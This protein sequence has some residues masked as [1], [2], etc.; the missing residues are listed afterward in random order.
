MCNKLIEPHAYLLRK[1]DHKALL[2]KIISLENFFDMIQ[3]KYL[4]FR[5]VDTYKDDTRD[6]DQPD[7]DKRISEKSKFESS[8][9]YNAKK[10]YA[11]CRSKT[12]ACCFSTENTEHIWEHYGDENTLCLIFEAEKLVTFLN[13]AFDK[14]SLVYFGKTLKNFFY[15]NYGLVTYGDIDDCFLNKYLPNPIK[16]VYFKS[17]KK[18]AEEKEFRISLSCC[19]IFKY[20]LDGAEFNFPESVQFGFDLIE[21]AKKGV[22]KEILV[23][24]KCIS[25]I[26]IELK[27]KLNNFFGDSVDLHI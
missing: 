11:E 17:A 15:I 2:Y 10:Y 12:Y 26:K 22:L 7:K 24:D 16:Y 25:T 6:S 9:D 23:S 19:G 18:Y 20:R 13:A 14:S 4:Y 1:P 21:A 27:E 5:R 3:N 8:P